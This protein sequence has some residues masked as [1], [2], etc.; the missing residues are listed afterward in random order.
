[1][2]GFLPNYDLISVYPP[3]IGS[4]GLPDQTPLAK[5][6]RGKITLWLGDQCV[7]E[8]WDK[9]IWRADKTGN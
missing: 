3:A 5:H 4:Q 2:G 9:D 7:V 1:M 8:V 6:I